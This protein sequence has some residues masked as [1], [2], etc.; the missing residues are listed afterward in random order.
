MEVASFQ[1]GV[2]CKTAVLRKVE[3]GYTAG[4]IDR[5]AAR[6]QESLSSQVLNRETQMVEDLVLETLTAKV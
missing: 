3:M 2:E 4:E 6:P 5:F 1:E